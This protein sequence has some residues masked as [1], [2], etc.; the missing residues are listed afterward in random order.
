M[1]PEQILQIPP[2]VLTQAQREFYFNEGYLCLE[3]AIDETWLARLRAATDELVERSRAVSKADTVFDLE[4]GH[5]A[6]APRPRH[7]SQPGR[8]ASGVLGLLPALPH[9]RHRGRSCWPRRE[10]PPLQT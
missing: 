1:T 4:P 2:K 9:A 5:S 6:A 3:R 8:A 7:V 10:V